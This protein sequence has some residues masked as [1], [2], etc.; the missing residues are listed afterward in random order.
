[1]FNATVDNI[2]SPVV[3]QILLKHRIKEILYFLVKKWFLEN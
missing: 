1:M 2:K 3:V